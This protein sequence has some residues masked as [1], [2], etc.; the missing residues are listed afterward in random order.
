MGGNLCGQDDFSFESDRFGGDNR[1]PGC[2]RC[3]FEV[4]MQDCLI[5]LS[6]FISLS[7]RTLY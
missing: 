6:S 2:S 7:S 5:T 3:D 1:I 4:G